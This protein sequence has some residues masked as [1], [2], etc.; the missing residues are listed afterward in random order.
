MIEGGGLGKF[1]PDEIGPIDVQ[2]PNGVVD[3]ARRR[4]GGGRR[5][6]Q[7]PRSPTSRG[8]V[9]DWAAPDPERASRGRP[10]APPP[11]LRR[12]RRDRA[13]SPTSARSPSCAPASRREMVTALARI[14]GRAVGIIANNPMHL[15]GAITSDGADKAARFMQL[16]DAFGLP[17]VSLIDTPGMMVGPDAEATGARPPLLAAVRRRRHRC[18]SRSVAVIL[19]KAYGLGAQAMAGGSLHEPLLTV[20]WPTA[21]LGA[22]GLEG[23]VK[24]GFRRELDAI[25]DETER[26]ERARGRWSPHAHEHA[27]ALNA[28][29]LF[30]LDDVIDPAETRACSPARSPR[31]RHGRPTA[32]GAVRRHLVA[33]AHVRLRRTTRARPNRRRGGRGRGAARRVASRRRIASVSARTPASEGRPAG[34][35]VGDVELPRRRRGCC[36][37]S[38]GRREPGARVRAGRGARVREVPARAVE[39]PSC[40]LSP[41]TCLSLGSRPP[42]RPRARVR[43]GHRLGC[44]VCRRRCRRRTRASTRQLVGVMC[45]R[46][47]GGHETSSRSRA[48]E[49]KDLFSTGSDRSGRGSPD[50]QLPQR[51][52]CCARTARGPSPSRP[53]HLAGQRPPAAAGPRLPSPRCPRRAAACARLVSGPARAGSAFDR[54]ARRRPRCAHRRQ[55]RAPRHRY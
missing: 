28:A 40:Q 38:P 44:R 7:A 30:E 26:A 22:M 8:R 53:R 17:I 2:A 18:G 6:R 11:R 51:R 21:E 52:Q 54:F 45:A 42:S 35:E 19:R 14:E 5:R 16:C 33:I 29:T 49:L 32:T 34:G 41:R 13:A 31:R 20:G 55:P 50:R 47:T 12:P 43:P 24:L 9:A 15:A 27:K 36:C 10:R 23:A 39:A 25:A 4:R 37:A 48:R 3:V 46:R 1:E